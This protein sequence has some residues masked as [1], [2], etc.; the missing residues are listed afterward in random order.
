[1]NTI[2]LNTIGTPK[3]S[4]GNSGGGNGGGGT[5]SAWRYFDVSKITNPLAIAEFGAMMLKM[6]TENGKVVLSAVYAAIYELKACVAYGIDMSA[7][8]NM[9]GDFTT[10][11]ELYQGFSETLEQFGIVEITEAEFYTL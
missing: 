8:T 10:W 9:T 6:Q 1:M 11:A 2:K 3:A 4:G 5:A 7:K